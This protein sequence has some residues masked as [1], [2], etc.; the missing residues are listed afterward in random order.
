MAATR[1]GSRMGKC[2][3]T[4]SNATPLS[5]NAPL[6]SNTQNADAPA[7]RASRLSEGHRPDASRRSWVRCNSHKRSDV[8]GQWPE[9][10]KRQG[11]MSRCSCVR[12]SPSPPNLTIDRT[13]FEM[14]LNLAGS[15]QF[16]VKRG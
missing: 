14:W 3:Q 9:D 8:H 5:S 16:T 4:R 13:V 2:H 11:Q 7:D 10:C 15:P 12:V 6:I 1:A